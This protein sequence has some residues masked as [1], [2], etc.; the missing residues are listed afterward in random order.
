M[1]GTFQVLV[2]YFLHCLGSSHIS[3]LVTL[4]SLIADTRASLN[5]VVESTNEVI[6]KDEASPL[7]SFCTAFVTVLLIF[8]KRRDL[9]ERESRLRE[10]RKNHCVVLDRIAQRM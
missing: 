5:S 7:V 10:W 6:D 3:R 1:A 8:S 4:Q 2:Q 9:S